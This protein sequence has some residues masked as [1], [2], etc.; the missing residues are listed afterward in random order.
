MTKRALDSHPL[1]AAI[2]VG[3]SRDTDDGVQLE[4]RDRRCRIVEVNFSCRELLLQT[5]RQRIRIDLKA[6]GQRGFR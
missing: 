6:N 5:V 4:E 2:R 1:D 3:E